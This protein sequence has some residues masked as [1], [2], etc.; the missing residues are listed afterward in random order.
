MS[1]LITLLDIEL[2]TIRE[3]GNHFLVHRPHFTLLEAKNTDTYELMKEAILLSFLSTRE[4]A[5]II[6]SIATLHGETAPSDY[7]TILSFE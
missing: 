3:F 6:D 5:I 1:I 7:T 4:F 2:K